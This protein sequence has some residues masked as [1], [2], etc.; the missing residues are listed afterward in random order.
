MGVKLGRTQ[1]EITPI[2]GFEKEVLLRR[3]GLFGPKRDKRTGGQR[4]AQ[5]S[6]NQI[7]DTMLSNQRG[8]DGQDKPQA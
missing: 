4:N 3:I 6:L 5:T 2:E 8:L 7:Y 1:L